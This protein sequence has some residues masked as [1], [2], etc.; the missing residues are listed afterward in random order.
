MKL[1]QG[2]VVVNTAG[3]HLPIYGHRNLLFA[4]R[5]EVL[6][7]LFVLGIRLNHRIVVLN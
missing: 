5:S 1:S 3:K 7:S 2:H 4:F 6:L